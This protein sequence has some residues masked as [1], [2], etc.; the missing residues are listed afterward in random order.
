M[1]VDVLSPTKRSP[2][3]GNDDNWD[4]LN[5]HI[6][7]GRMYEESSS[8]ESRDNSTNSVPYPQHNLVGSAPCAPSIPYATTPIE[9]P[10]LQKKV[11]IKGK[12]QRLLAILFW[13]CLLLTVLFV[14]AIGIVSFSGSVNGKIF[15]LYG[16]LF[17][18]LSA[19]ILAFFIA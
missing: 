1:I 4:N 14:I 2:Y 11:T 3:M 12:L 8:D 18:F 15:C 10:R 5:I 17:S 6:G 19:I 16:I 7:Y 13:S 9:A